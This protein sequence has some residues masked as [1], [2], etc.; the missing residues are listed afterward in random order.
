MI[1]SVDGGI[2]WTLAAK[3]L[4]PAALVRDLAIDPERPAT[5]YAATSQGV[6]VSEDGAQHWSSLSKGLTSL[7]V[8][9]ISLDPFS[10]ATL[11][12]GTHGD[13]GLFVFTRPGR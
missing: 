8:Q 12:A 10:P 1:K 13:G 3:E 2:S 7:D 9:R 6:F 5:L 11:Y 4:P